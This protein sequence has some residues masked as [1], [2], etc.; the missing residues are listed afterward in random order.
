MMVPEGGNHRRRMLRALFGRISQVGG[1]VRCSEDWRL[2]TAA[3]NYVLTR[4]GS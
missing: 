4:K 2:R 1:R 3:E